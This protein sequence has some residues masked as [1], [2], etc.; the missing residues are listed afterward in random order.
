MSGIV[1]ILYNPS[2]GRS[3]MWPVYYYSNKILG[4]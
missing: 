4:V 1:T 2:Q 3:Q